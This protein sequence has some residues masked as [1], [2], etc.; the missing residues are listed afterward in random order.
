MRHSRLIDAEINVTYLGL[1]KENW[2][3]KKKYVAASLQRHGRHGY[4]GILFEEFLMRERPI[5]LT[6]E[7]WLS[8]RFDQIGMVGHG[9]IVQARACACVLYEELKRNPVLVEDRN[10]GVDGNEFGERGTG[11][12]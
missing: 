2:C 5:P 4:I 7:L 3:V 9:Q 11:I 12:E 10:S 8:R 6:D 1:L